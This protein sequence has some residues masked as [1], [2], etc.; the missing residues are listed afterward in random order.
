MAASDSLRVGFLP[1]RTLAFGSV[2]AGLT[3]IG[4]ASTDSSRQL[5]V[6]NYT[7]QTLM[8]SSDGITDHF[9]LAQNAS[10]ILDFTTNRTKNATGLYLASGTTIF[11]RHLGVAPASGSVFVTFIIGQN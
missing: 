4:A 5:L 7:N 2:G 3:A 9:P 11:V 8:F 6:Q 10:L 1:V